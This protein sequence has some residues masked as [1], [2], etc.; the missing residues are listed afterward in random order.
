MNLIDGKDVERLNDQ[1]FRAVLNALFNA[2]AGR[3]HVPLLDLDLT[4]RQTDPDAGVD[5]RVKWPSS[6][7]DVLKRGEN[8]IQYKS[9][10]LK[11][12]DLREEFK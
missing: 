2:E 5:A 4:T 11:L 10:K 6:D 3:H 9:G 1:E 12:K 7:H 8:V